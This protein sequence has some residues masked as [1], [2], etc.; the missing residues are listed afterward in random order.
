MSGHGWVVVVY[1]RR[2]HALAVRESTS[3]GSGKFKPVPVTSAKEQ[4]MEANEEEFIKL[5][6]EPAQDGSSSPRKTWALYCDVSDME[7]VCPIDVDSS[8]QHVQKFNPR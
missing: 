4:K 7:Q 1:N 3:K 6:A 5:D 2:G 8:Q